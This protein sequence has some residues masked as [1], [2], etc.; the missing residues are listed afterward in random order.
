MK[1]TS[2]KK[3]MMNVMVSLVLTVLLV[4]C[5]STVTVKE[6]E[7]SE[8]NRIV[9]EEV[10]PEAEVTEGTAEAAEEVSEASTEEAEPDFEAQAA[11]IIEELGLDEEM[12]AGLAENIRIIWEIYG[13]DEEEYAAVMEEIKEELAYD[14][15]KMADAATAQPQE[16][17]EI[18]WDMANIPEDRAWVDELY[19]KLISNDY[20]GVMAILADDT[21]ADKAEPYK[22]VAYVYDA[23]GYKLVTTDGKI[24]GLHLPKDLTECADRAAFFSEVEENDYGFSHTQA[25]DYMVMMYYDPASGV[26]SY[27]WLNGDTTITHSDGSTFELTG[28][29]VYMVWAM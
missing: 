21:I 6:A 27:E 11:A 5:G 1:K 25:G 20:E 28:S 17:E 7:V 2:M 4:G 10:I 19:N 24:V 13:E 29:T 12:N 15:M 3:A 14:A 16:K 26:Q 18:H 23:Y 22:Y 8:E 9:S